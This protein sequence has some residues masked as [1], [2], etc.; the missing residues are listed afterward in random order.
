MRSCAL[1]RHYQPFLAVIP[2]YEAD[3]PRVT[4]P[5]AAQSPFCPKTSRRFARLAC[6]RHAASV[7]PE[8]GS[9]S[10][11]KV[12]VQDQNQAWLNFY[13]VYLLLG[14]SLRTILFSNCSRI[15]HCSV[16]KVLFAFLWFCFALLR[17]LLYFTTSFCVCQALFS[18][19]FETVFSEPVSSAGPPERGLC[20]V[21]KALKLFELFV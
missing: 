3:Y 1:M 20:E 14:C 15:C 19:F 12:F 2:L 18:T 21:W 4:H 16:I 6:V 7:H 5:S 11:I 17:Q 13:P 8:P 10:Q 9:N